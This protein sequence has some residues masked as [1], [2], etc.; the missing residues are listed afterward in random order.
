MCKGPVARGCLT[1]GEVAVFRA[2]R[3]AGMGVRPGCRVGELTLWD[4]LGH[5]YIAGLYLESNKDPRMW[6]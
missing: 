1:I 6:L 3:G 2:Q 5:S 4:T